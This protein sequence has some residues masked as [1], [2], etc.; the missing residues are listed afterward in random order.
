MKSGTVTI[1]CLYPGQEFLYPDA[2]NNS[3]VLELSTEEFRMLFTG[4]LEQEGEQSL[5]SE[6]RMEQYDVLKVGHHGSSG[7]SSNE[8][9]QKICPQYALISCGRNNSYGHPHEETLERFREADIGIFRTDE[10]GAIM[11]EPDGKRRKITY[12]KKQE[13]GE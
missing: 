7:A 13:A 10:Q 8:F 5:E 11:L 2:N 9:I 3:M 1:R 4:D 6:A 12:F